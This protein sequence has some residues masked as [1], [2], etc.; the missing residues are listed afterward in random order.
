MFS[1]QHVIFSSEYSIL[2]ARVNLALV[3]TGI[4]L[5]LVFCLFV[6]KFFLKDE[7]LVSL[8]V[9]FMSFR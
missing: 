6:N 3:V 1:V 4:W 2:F 7:R 5:I 8:F 9:M